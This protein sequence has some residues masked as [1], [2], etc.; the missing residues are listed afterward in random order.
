M[1]KVLMGVIMLCVGWNGMLFGMGNMP[2]VKKIEMSAKE[3]STV[4]APDFN[5]PDLNNGAMHSLESFRG[6]P[7]FIDFWASWCPPCKNAAPYIEKLHEEF[8]GRANVIGINLDKDPDSAKKFIKRKN[9]SNIQLKGIGTN[10]PSE[11]GV[12]GIPSFFIMNKNGEIV[13]KAV[14]F[15]AG[16]Y[17][18]WRKVL[19]ELINE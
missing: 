9:I 1:K 3:A 19:K 10:V 8:K 13:D 5:L 14:G 11:Y 2:K 12:Q 16:Y 17:D 6:Q 15:T 18:K 4:S 7:L